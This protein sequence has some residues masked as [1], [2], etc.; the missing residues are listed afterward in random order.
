MNAAPHAAT[1]TAVRWAYAAVGLAGV[2]LALAAAI[3]GD[4]VGLAWAVLA[5]GLAF[6]T[7]ALARLPG[8]ASVARWVSAAYLAVLAGA[9]IAAGFAG[10]GLDEASRVEGFVRDANVLGA[11]LVVAAAAWAAVAPARRWAAWAVALGWPLAATAVLYTGS[12][13]AAGA[14]VLA[15]AAWLVVRFRR[16]RGAWALP[17]LAALVVLAA[18]AWQRGVV[19]ASPNLLAAPSDFAHREWRHDLAASVEVTAAAGEGPFDGTRAQQLRA[20]AEPDGRALLLQTIGRSEPGVPYVASLYLRADASQRVVVSTHLSETTCDVG[21]AWT[22]C[23]T[24][25][26]IGDGVLQAQFYLLAVEPGGTLDVLGYGA[27]YEVGTQA[28][29]FRARRFAWLPQALVRRLDV[30]EVDLLPEDRRAI[31]TAAY[32][33]ART[34]PWTGVGASAA[35]EALS[36]RTSTGVVQAHNGLL[37]LWL[38]RGVLGV[39][40]AALLAAALASAQPAGA[41]RAL[42]P[43][44]VALVLTNTW[45]VTASDAL[46]V[47]PTLLAFAGVGSALRRRSTPASPPR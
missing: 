34:A 12:R 26:G 43:L 24:P 47:V 32:E 5:P 27:Q 17:A 11:A 25:P 35:S 6:A 33:V 7:I 37:H 20:T 29:P 31:W 10:V 4:V 45:D 1:G 38:V 36:T 46:V 15:A 2:L 3:T 22:R 14:C 41:W 30:R 23:T 9:T 19:E 13:A 44:L 8:F 18:L 39:V 42:A 28:T 40:A 16:G 21:A